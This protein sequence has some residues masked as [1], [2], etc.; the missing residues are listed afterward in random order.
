M[1]LLSQWICLF[2]SSVCSAKCLLCAHE[3]DR[4][5]EEAK[6]QYEKALKITESGGRVAFVTK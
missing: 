6:K 5:A 2:D 3:W 1:L 4:K